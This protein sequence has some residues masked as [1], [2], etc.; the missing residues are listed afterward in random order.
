MELALLMLV[1]DGHGWVSSVQ[2]TRDTTIV[3]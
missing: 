1:V 3:K 2:D